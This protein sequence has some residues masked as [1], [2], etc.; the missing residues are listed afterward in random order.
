[1]TLCTTCKSLDFRTLLLTCLQQARERQ[2]A[3]DIGYDDA[4]LASDLLAPLRHHCDIFEVGKSSSTCKLCKI[5]FQAFEKRQVADVED[6]RGLQI[7]FRTFSNRIQVCYETEELIQLCRLDV[8]MNED[9]VEQY[10]QLCG[11]KE[12]DSP[13]I[14]RM[15][16]KDPGSKEA[17]AIASSW[18]RSCLESHADCKLTAQIQNTP[19][20]LINVGSETRHPFLVEFPL[21]SQQ[22]E[23]LSL[24]Y[25][26]GQEDPLMKLTADTRERLE[27]GIPLD[28]LDPTIRD[29]ILVTRGL[30]LDFIWIDALCIIQEDNNKDWDDQAPKMNEIYGGSL[31]TLVVASSNSVKSGFL[32]ERVIPYVPIL[33]SNSSSGE[34]PN[35]EPPTR[36]YF[37]PEWDPDEDKLTG[38]WTNRGWTMQEGLLPS[39]LLHFTASQMI[40]KC[41][42]EEKFERGVT[43]SVNDMVS[44]TLARSDD[45][46]FGSAWFWTLDSFMKFKRFP[47]HLPTNPDYPLLSDPNTFHLWYDLV[48]EYTPRRFTKISDRLVAIS[49]LARIFGSIIR[50]HE[51]VVGLWKPDLIRGL[52]WYTEGS[53]LIPRQSVDSMRSSYSNFPSWSWASVGY[54]IVKFRQKSSDIL[55]SL[56]QVE[57]VSIELT[58]QSQPF[59]NVKGGKITIKGP[60]KRV[61]RLYNADWSSAEASMSELERHLSEIVDKESLGGLA[62]RFSSP[63]GGGHYAALQMLGDTHSLDLLVLE[64]TGDVSNGINVY[65]RVGMDTL[66]YFCDADV[67]SPDL[68]NK[69]KESESSLSARLGPQRR[70]GRKVKG[71]RAVVTELKSEPWGIETIIII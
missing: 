64:A 54:E 9:D 66:R 57:S 26:W 28:S 55:T 37:S 63:S 36:V 44:D 60:L 49:G 4:P 29:A 17:F 67:A 41:C 21:A 69:L 30:G 14:L 15:N 71:T 47:S 46:S 38:P 1:M 59:G 11:I 45:I 42:E 58:D 61:S 43:K 8:Y 68:I 65:R 16:E 23:W 39:R 35:A 20:R 62:H 32:K 40:W 53:M 24:S 13:P 27:N 31:L 70:K 56:S 48:E 34:S 33:S 7:V 22:V 19:K 51:Y 18:L 50:T 10:F 52:L 5:I 25:C 6:A 2:E 3:R 12:D